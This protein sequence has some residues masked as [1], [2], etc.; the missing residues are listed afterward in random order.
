MEACHDEKKNRL[1]VDM[2]K[3]EMGMTDGIFKPKWSNLWEK[4]NF[5]L[6]ESAK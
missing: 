1:K 6:I 4:S 3:M 5:D 2:M